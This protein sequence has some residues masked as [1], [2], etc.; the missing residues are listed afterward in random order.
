MILKNS[1]AKYSIQEWNKSYF[2]ESAN[3]PIQLITYQIYFYTAIA[4]ETTAITATDS[5]YSLSPKTQGHE[6]IL[7]AQARGLDET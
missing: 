5:T 4:F 6:G 7:E 3:L 2:H 1:A